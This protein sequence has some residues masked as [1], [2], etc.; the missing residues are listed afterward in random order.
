MIC[1]LRWSPK[2]FDVS[3]YRGQSIVSASFCPDL[4]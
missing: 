2:Q 4:N 1:A 3:T